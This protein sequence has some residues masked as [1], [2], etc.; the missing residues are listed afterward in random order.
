[1]ENIPFGYSKSQCITRHCLHTD[2]QQAGKAFCCT[3]SAIQCGC[4]HC[5][6]RRWAIIMQC[7]C[8]KKLSAKGLFNCTGA[9]AS[10]SHSMPV[11]SSKRGLP[12]AVP[13][14]QPS[15]VGIL[16][17][18]HPSSNCRHSLLRTCDCCSQIDIVQLVV[19]QSL[20]ACILILTVNLTMM[21]NM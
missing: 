1:M 3:S 18:F 20:L 19:I 10:T 21:T 6:K 14:P 17:Q 4:L 12:P 15:L 8:T 9:Q 11:Q 16:H 7:M 2:K 5:T 13:L